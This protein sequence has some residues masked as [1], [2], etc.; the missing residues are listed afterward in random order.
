MLAR[1]MR[2][3]GKDPSRFGKNGDIDLVA[4]SEAYFPTH[5]VIRYRQFSGMKNQAAACH[6]SQGGHKMNR[7]ITGWFATL[8]A[9][10]Q[11]MRAYPPATERTK[12]TDLFTGL[13][14]QW[15]G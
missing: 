4:I 8:F 15:Q 5:A 14:V 10:D 7:G 1:I 13:D 9:R 12:E 11:Y 6:R 2:L 3:F